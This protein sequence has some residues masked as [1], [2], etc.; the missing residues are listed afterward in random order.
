M[1]KRSLWLAGLLVL[2]AS[3]VVGPGATAGTEKS[4]AGTVVFIHDQE[5]PTLREQL[6]GQQPLCNRSDYQPDLRR[7]REAERKGQPHSAA[8]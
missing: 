3:L 8:L 7:L 5:P 4:Q 6:D 1:R 2:V